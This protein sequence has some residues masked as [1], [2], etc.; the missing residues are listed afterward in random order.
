MAAPDI[1]PFSDEHIEDAGR[2]LAARHARHREAEPLLPARFAE[3]SAA[4]EEVAAAWQRD[5]ASGAAA[6][7]DGRLVGFLVGAPRDDAIWGE[8]VW[9]EAAGHAVEDAEDARDLYASAAGRW[10]EEG[11]RRHYVLVPAGEAPTNMRIMVIKRLRSVNDA[12]S[13]VLKPAVR[14]VTARKY[15]ARIRSVHEKPAMLCENST[16]MNS[17]VPLPRRIAVVVSTRRL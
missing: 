2:L 10:F 5:G 16:R 6:V 11:R 13:T 17:N 12:V 1:V 15:E 3:A 4:Q 9:V 8:N 7:R 14:G